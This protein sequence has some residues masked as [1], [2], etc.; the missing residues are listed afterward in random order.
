[1]I[2]GAYC[3]RSCSWRAGYVASSCRRFYC[4]RDRRRRFVR[5]R[6]APQD[7]AL[8]AGD[9]KVAAAADDRGG[10]H[11]ENRTCFA[12]HQQGPPIFAIAAARER[13]FAIDEEE[14]GRQTAFIAKFLDGN[15]E[16]YL[17]GKGTGRPGRYGGLCLVVAGGGRLSAGETTAAVAEYLL[18]RHKD[19]DHWLNISNRPPSEA[20]P[21]TTTYVALYGLSFVRHGG[22]ERANRRADEQ[23]REW[24]V[25]TPAKD[26]ED[27]VFRLAWLCKRPT[28]RRAKSPPRRRSCWQAARGRRLGAAR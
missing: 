1:M 22:A 2:A 26:N 4:R 27:R 11:R 13:G 6:S 3:V 25:K 21:F 17:Q 15:R 23:V 7:A 5:L 12:C 28:C 20:G 19:K 24:L 10:G 16:N 8:R 18:L 9:R 14:I